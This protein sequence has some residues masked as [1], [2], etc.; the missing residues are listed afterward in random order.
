MSVVSHGLI[1]WLLPVVLMSLL[2][3]SASLV[4]Q[5]LTAV[6]LVDE[7]EHPWSM[8]FLPDGEVLVSEREGKLRRI[9]DNTLLP[10]SVSGLPE[11]AAQG[12]GGLL[13][14]ALHPQFA[15]N[16]WLY[17]AYAAEG[18]DGYSTHLAR[19]RYQDGALTQV[20][21][22]FAATPQSFGGQHFGG[23][24]A[25]DRAGYVYLTLG[26][27]G[28]RENAQMLENHAGSVIRLHDDGRIP[29]NNPFVNT[30]GAQP[31]IYTYGHRNVQGIALHPTTGQVWTGEHGPQGGDEI[32]ILRAGANYGWPVITYGEEYGGG[33]VG[34]GLK[35]KAGM[36]Q[37]VLYWTPSIAPAGMTFYTGDKYPGWQGNLLVSALK[38]ALISRVTL[39][40]NRYVD[41]ERLLEDE[42][43]RIRDIQQA[44]DG[45]LYVLT[46]E[47]DGALYRL[48]PGS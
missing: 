20:E 11:I 14:L 41:E 16:R 3:F 35:E 19:G 4:A 34:A 43:G 46:D 48:K 5:S 9:Q 29:A 39:D 13:G 25:F 33:E 31:E 1:R 45:Y 23:R 7:L 26:D 21:V 44:P 37:P 17:L 27:R 38:F 12:Q 24:I 15:Q 6:K 40:G 18:D 32:N 10:K 22:L 36:E 42:I 2:F 8:V 28:E 30:A 47:S